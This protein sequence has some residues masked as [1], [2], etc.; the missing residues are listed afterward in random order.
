MYYGQ[1]KVNGDQIQI[2]RHPKIDHFYE[3]NKKKY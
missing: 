2:R 1:D 3:I